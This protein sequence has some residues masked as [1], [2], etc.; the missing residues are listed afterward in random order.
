GLRRYIR[1]FLLWGSPSTGFFLVKV[2]LISGLVGAFLLTG[3]A[4]TVLSE[5]VFSIC[6]D[7]G[8][9]L[10][11]FGLALAT[12]VN[13]GSVA[14]ILG[15]PLNMIVYEAVRRF[16]F[17]EYALVMGIPATCGLFLN[18]LCLYWVYYRHME[19]AGNS[20]ISGTVD[21]QL[22]VDEYA[23]ITQGVEPHH[24]SK[25]LIVAITQP[26]TYGATKSDCLISYD[27]LECQTNEQDFEIP[28]TIGAEPTPI[29]CSNFST[30]PESISPIQFCPKTPPATPLFE[31]DGSRKTELVRTSHECAQNIKSSESSIQVHPAELRSPGPVPVHKPSPVPKLQIPLRQPCVGEPVFYGGN[32]SPASAHSSRL[33]RS[34]RSYGRTRITLYQN[35]LGGIG[36]LWR[37]HSGGFRLGILLMIMYTAMVL[38]FNPGWTYFTTA[39]LLVFIDGNAAAASLCRQSWIFLCY[40]CGVFVLSRGFLATPIPRSVWGLLEPLLHFDDWSVYSTAWVFCLIT[41]IPSILFGSIPTLLL[42]LPF[43]QEIED[44]TLSLTLIFV[45]LWCMN[46]SGNLTPYESITNAI[47]TDVYKQYY[48]D[49]APSPYNQAPGMRRPKVWLE[50]LSVWIR[51]TSWTTFLL[52]IIGI[53]LV[54]YHVDSQL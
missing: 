27:S 11:P 31:T 37:S 52:T 4:L 38:N 29:Y 6:N 36:G 22:V 45:L 3:G 23:K 51:Y 8:L 28:T 41:M 1:R 32:T 43:L 40:L 16:S 5:V 12:S 13:I 50:R 47:V 15:S 25:G 17:V 9:H 53:P 34:P 42:V 14:T 54:V 49:K 48:T 35:A 18:T 10:H 46:L 19:V 7:H 33:A 44:P 21:Y 20:Q 24:Q 2:S 26:I 30:S 39:T